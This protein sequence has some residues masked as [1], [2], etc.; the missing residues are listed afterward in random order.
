[1][2]ISF[3]SKGISK[4]LASWCKGCSKCKYL[5]TLFLWFLWPKLTNLEFTRYVFIDWIA[6]WREIKTNGKDH[7]TLRLALGELGS[8]WQQQLRSLQLILF[9]YGGAVWLM[10]RRCR[11]TYERMYAGTCASNVHTNG[12]K[13]RIGAVPFCGGVGMCCY[14]PLLSPGSWPLVQ[15]N[16][17]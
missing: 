5:W 2:K 12:G 16:F 13:K 15:H 6:T 11:Y 10:F 14:L 3:S 1:M 17:F 9:H 4:L 8:S 7:E